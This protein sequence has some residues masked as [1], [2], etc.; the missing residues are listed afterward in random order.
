MSTPQPPDSERDRLEE[1]I[2][3]TLR[4]GTEAELRGLAK[5]LAAT[6]D[7]RLFGRTEFASTS[8][9]P[10]STFELARALDPDDESVREGW[11]EEWCHR[12]KHQGGQSVLDGL[13]ELFPACTATARE[14]LSDRIQYIGNQVHRM[15]WLCDHN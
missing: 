14:T 15:D 6:P 12:L 5:L 7:E 13:R 2:F 10:P 9:T 4:I 8:I 1:Q 3:Q 11:L